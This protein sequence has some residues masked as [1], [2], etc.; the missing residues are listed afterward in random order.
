[1]EL[2]LNRSELSEPMGM[3]EIQEIQQNRFPSYFIDRVEELIPGVKATGFKN[4]TANEWFFPT[5]F[6]GDPIVPGYVLVEAA[7]QMFLMT[8]LSLK[9]Y[10]GMR[11][12]FISIEQF[13]FRRKVIPGD[14]L[15]LIAEL[16]EFR[17]GIAKGKVTGY[18]DDKLAISGIL[19][20]GIP[21][22]MDEISQAMKLKASEK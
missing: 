8:F 20:V 13:S 5:H 6:P 15:Q 2:H 17:R 9:D 1:M 3:K 4:F 7:T 19:T 10:G 18:V 11:T 16:E 22:V 21:N 14:R 12:S